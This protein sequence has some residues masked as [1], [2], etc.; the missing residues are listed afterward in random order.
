MVARK[1]MLLPLN[2]SVGIWLLRLLQQMWLYCCK[3]ISG[4]MKEY[5]TATK[6]FLLRYSGLV[7]CNKSVFPHK[8][9]FMGCVWTELARIGPG[10]ENGDPLR[11][12]S[13]SMR[14]ISS[15]RLRCHSGSLLARGSSRRV[16]HR[17][18]DLHLACACADAR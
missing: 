2:I 3:I 11:L 10:R 18:Q 17:L 15:R 14:S 5:A 16:R 1:K 12:L 8:F 6:H 9:N 4:C 7:G 13:I